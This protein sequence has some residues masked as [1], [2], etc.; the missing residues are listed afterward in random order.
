MKSRLEATEAVCQATSHPLTKAGYLVRALEALGL[1][2][3]EADD[4]ISAMNDRYKRTAFPSR[5]KQDHVAPMAVALVRIDRR[6]PFLQQLYL[7]PK[8]SR[9]R[10]RCPAKCVRDGHRGRPVQGRLR[11][12]E[13][14]MAEQIKPD[15]KL[16]TVE[17]AKVVPMKAIHEQLIA[18]GRVVPHPTAPSFRHPRRL[19]AEGFFTRTR[20]L[21][22]F[23]YG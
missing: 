3:F 16:L 23:S 2:K 13:R 21:W 11:V 1:L 18:N 9:S 19:S 6:T 15:A 14:A 22:K 10:S 12:V 5:A 8:V 7:A 20:P 17:R 4:S